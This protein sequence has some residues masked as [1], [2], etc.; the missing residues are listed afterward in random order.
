MVTRRDRL[1]AH[2]EGHPKKGD[3]CVAPTARD[4]TDTFL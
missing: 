4:M 3:A 2:E 1:L